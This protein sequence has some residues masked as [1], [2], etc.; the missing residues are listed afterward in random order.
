MPNSGMDSAHTDARPGF[1]W[2]SRD[3]EDGVPLLYALHELHKTI[4]APLAAWADVNRKLFTN[5][6]SPFAY[7]PLSRTIAASQEVL[8][9]LMRS[10][11]KPAGRIDHA[12]ARGKEV[13]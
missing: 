9:R 1:S 3:P 6:Y 13:S 5:P 12:I 11:E 2:R 4:T 8:A 10:Y 7:H